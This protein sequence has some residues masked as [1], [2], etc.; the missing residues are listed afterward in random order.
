MAKSTCVWIVDDDRSI[1]WVLEKAMQRENI[2][3][4]VFNSA[5]DALR[6][7]DRSQPAVVLSDI[8]MPGASGLELLQALKERL[9]KVPVIIMT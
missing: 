2:P 4:M 7:L 6:E 1:R 3:C 5:S 9:P 8:R